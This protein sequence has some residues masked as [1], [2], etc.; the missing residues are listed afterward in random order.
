[1]W[2]APRADITSAF[3]GNLESEK[4]PDCAQ[5]Q[6]TEQNKAAGGDMSACNFE[7]L[8]QFVNNQLNPDKQLDVYD[9]LDRC[10]ICRDAVYQLSRDLD[11]ALFSY[12]DH[13]AKDYTFVQ[14]IE[15]DRSGRAQVGAN[16]LARPAMT[17]SSNRPH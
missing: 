10:S 3:F 8:L 5:T 9:H 7:C 17:R 6:W 13:C 2:E 14:K 11:K 15:M 1:M 4:L 16:A 12:C